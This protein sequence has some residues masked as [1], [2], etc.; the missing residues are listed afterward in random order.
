MTPAVEGKPAASRR[1]AFI[2]K[3]LTLPEHATAAVLPA[4]T[5]DGLLKVPEDVQQVGWWDGSA[6][7]GEPFGSTVIAGHVDSNTDGTG[8]FARLLGVEV[9]DT[10]TLAADSHRL[11]YQVTSVRE[12]ARNALAT[13]S[14]ALEQSGPHRLVL[15]TCTGDY[16]RDR[17][18]YESNLVVLAEPRGFPR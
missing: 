3:Q 11:K 7:A 5:V 15:I 13:D 14:Q 9:G 18:G 2:P 10:I 17:G 16:D 8:F 12:V 6:R 4:A 1:V